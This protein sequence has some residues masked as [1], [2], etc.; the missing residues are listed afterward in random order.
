[1]D[2]KNMKQEKP[3]ARSDFK[4]MKTTSVKQLNSRIDVLKKL[5]T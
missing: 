4:N 3:E 5:C 1:M 2:M